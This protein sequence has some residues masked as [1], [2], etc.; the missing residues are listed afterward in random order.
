[1]KCFELLSY[2]EILLKYIQ[3]LILLSYNFYKSLHL[4][5]ILDAICYLKEAFYILT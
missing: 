2:I 4:K 5:E 3:L 1:M